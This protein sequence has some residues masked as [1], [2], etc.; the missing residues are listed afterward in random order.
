MPNQQTDKSRYPSIYSAGKFITAAQYI[1]ELLYEQYCFKQQKEA[2]LQTWQSNEGK[3]FLGGQLRVTHNLLKKYSEKAIIAVIK[4]RKV[5]N[6][7]VK[8]I[9]PYIARKQT[10]LDTPTTKPNL[11]TS[12]VVPKGPITFGTRTK[13]KNTLDKLMDIDNNG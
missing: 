11:A 1:I 4:E 10:L 12:F 6:L 7:R 9:V 3:K 5:D 2:T 8:W 13:K